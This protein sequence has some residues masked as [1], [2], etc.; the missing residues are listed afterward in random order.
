[1]I[2]AFK[3]EHPRY[4]LSLKNIVEKDDVI[5]NESFIDHTILLIS[6]EH[7]HDEL[8]F[9]NVLKKVCLCRAR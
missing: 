5:Q 2:S 1:M 9:V 3:N 4:S 7:L 6:F 8:D